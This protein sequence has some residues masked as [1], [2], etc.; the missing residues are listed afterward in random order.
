MFFGKI[1]SQG[2]TFKF[3]PSEAAT[4]ESDILS[5]TNVVLAPTSK[6]GASLYIKKDNQ[7]F[8]VAS[9]T[10]ASPQVVI[11]VFLALQDE[12]EF[13]VK[14]NGTL[15][16]TGFFEPEQEEPVPFPEDDSEEEDKEEEEEEEEDE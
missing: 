10:K 12:A 7:E 1:L 15:H 2:Q 11:N 8:L 9:L 3:A 14:G 13:I 6:E 5:L 16:I 4:F